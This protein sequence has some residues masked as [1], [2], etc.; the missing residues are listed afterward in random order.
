MQWIGLTSVVQGLGVTALRTWDPDP[1]NKRPARGPLNE[2]LP[3]IHLQATP[4]HPLHSPPTLALGEC[5]FLPF[6]SFNTFTSIL[7]HGFLLFH[8]PFLFADPSFCR[9]PPH[10]LRQ[11]CLAF[12]LLVLA[13][14]IRSKSSH[15][16]C[17]SLRRPYFPGFFSLIL[18][19]VSS[20]TT[21]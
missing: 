6:L 16:S 5:G 10:P 11:T 3:K 4:T 18:T 2:Q 12:P 17:P 19:A 14:S 9:L 20:L 8:H 21:S 1:E 15:L 7:N 13:S